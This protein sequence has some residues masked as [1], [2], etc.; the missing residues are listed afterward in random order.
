MLSPRAQASSSA[1]G[2][3]RKVRRPETLDA[4]LIEDDQTTLA[5]PKTRASRSEKSA[6]GFDDDEHFASLYSRARIKQV[7]QALGFALAC[8]LLVW[9]WPSTSEV[10][11]VVRP[12]A[13][14]SIRLPPPLV[15]PADDHT[16][17]S[18]LH[19]SAGTCDEDERLSVSD[20]TP[21]TPDKVAKP[22]RRAV[23]RPHKGNRGVAPWVLGSV[24]QPQGD[25]GVR[26][27]V[28]IYTIPTG[29]EA[30][31]NGRP[32]GRTPLDVAWKPG[33]PFEVVLV[34]PG[35]VTRTIAFVPESPSAVLRVELTANATDE[36]DELVARTAE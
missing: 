30:R 13:P 10:A 3:Q 25:H 6:R 22:S 1:N 19:A 34:L 7:F 12:S 28:F 21:T 15:T 9:L 14:A 5:V 18:P 8:A 31:V 20:A 24:P 16:P 29:A 33:K 26:P 17:S 2:L 11:P 23:N 4:W 27:S 36:D 32:V 35:H